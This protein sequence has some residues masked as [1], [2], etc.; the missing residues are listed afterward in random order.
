[1]R[2][3]IINKHPRHQR[4][5]AHMIGAL[6]IDAEMATA[7]SLRESQE[8]LEGGK[9]FDVAIVDIDSLGLS[10]VRRLNECYPELTLLAFTFPDKSVDIHPGIARATFG[11]SVLA[12]RTNAP[13]LYSRDATDTNVAHLPSTLDVETDDKERIHLTP[14]QMDVLRLIS[15]GHSTK[16]IARMLEIAEGTVKVHTMAIFR[17]LGVTNRTQAA[18]RGR[19]LLEETEE[20]DDPD[21]EQPELRVEYK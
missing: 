16:A 12:K 9:P 17:E 8:I 13:Q 4:T 7:S 6:N 18:T 1:M 10:G 2:V 11:L 3:L 19:E 14:R 15:D 21:D 20:T 5:F